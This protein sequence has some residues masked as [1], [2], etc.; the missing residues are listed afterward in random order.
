MSSTVMSVK[1]NDRQYNGLNTI[2][3][4]TFFKRLRLIIRDTDHRIDTIHRLDRSRSAT[5]LSDIKKLLLLL[6]NYR[7]LSL[8]Y[9]YKFDVA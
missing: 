1:N 6:Y 3:V 2:L 9:N 7:S 8:K 5:R 4:G